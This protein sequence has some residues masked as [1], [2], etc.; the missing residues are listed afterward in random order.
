MNTGVPK[1][2]STWKTVLKF[3]NSLQLCATNF[4][5]FAQLAIFLGANSVTKEKTP[6]P[7]SKNSFS[8][9][10]GIGALHDIIIIQNSI[11]KHFPY[12]GAF[13]KIMRVLR[14]MVV[15]ITHIEKIE[16]QKRISVT[17]TYFFFLY[18]VKMKTKDMPY[19]LLLNSSVPGLVST[20]AVSILSVLV[21]EKLVRVQ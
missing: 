8:L 4:E 17:W 10:Q 6:W 16:T 2:A 18:N 19:Q 20:A 9:T 1:F 12:N 7:K 15:V 3:T 14:K 5:I 13:Y 21:L 11:S